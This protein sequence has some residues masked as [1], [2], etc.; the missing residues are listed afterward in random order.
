MRS[1]RIMRQNRLDLRRDQGDGSYVV[2]FG[3]R[4]TVEERHARRLAEG[5]A[6]IAGMCGMRVGELPDIDDD[7]LF[8]DVT[9]E[10][11]PL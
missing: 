7:R 11:E 9:S 5:R 8:A 10:R 2:P 6:R 1:D 4:E 3:R